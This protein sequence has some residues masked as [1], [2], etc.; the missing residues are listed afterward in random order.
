ME[1]GFQTTL[2]HIHKNYKETS[3]NLYKVNVLKY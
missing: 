1:I 2:K 3:Y